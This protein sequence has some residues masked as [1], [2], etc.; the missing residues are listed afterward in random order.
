[1]SGL[2]LIGGLLTAGAQIASGVAANRQAQQEA[3]NQEAAAK[4]D[5]ANSQQ[6]AFEKKREGE[7]MLSRQQALAAASGGGA[8]DPTILKIMG[9]TATQSAL[10]VRQTVAG[11]QQSLAN[12]FASARSTRAAGRASFLGSMFDAAGTF[13]GTAYK[14]GKTKGFG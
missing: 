4:Q 14:F 5:F 6:Q 12:G 7:L 13:A 3:L 9:N 10:N 8:D 2:E 1:M 11:G